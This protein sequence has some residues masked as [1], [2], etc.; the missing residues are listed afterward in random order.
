MSEENN[1]NNINSNNTNASY[2][3]HFFLD[4]I[5]EMFKIQSQSEMDQQISQNLTTIIKTF[6]QFSKKLYE[7]KKISQNE[8]ETIIHCLKFVDMLNLF[9]PEHSWSKIRNLMNNIHDNL[10]DRKDLNADDKEK[11]LK[12]I[13]YTEMTLIY[14]YRNKYKNLYFND[15]SALAYEIEQNL[16]QVLKNGKFD[17]RLFK[18]M[19]N[20]FYVVQKKIE[21]HKR[22]EIQKK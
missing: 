1:Y 13:K 18:Q 17:Q 3:Q 21:V 7:Y 12:S 14:F 10:F 5:D 11:I 6:T 2:N 16:E 8:I 19:Q 22:E 20:L 4:N 9:F 15:S